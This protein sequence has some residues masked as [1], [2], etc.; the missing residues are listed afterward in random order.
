[1]IDPKSEEPPKRRALIVTRP[2]FEKTDHRQVRAQLAEADRQEMLATGERVLNRSSR[3]SSQNLPKP[4][5][6]LLPSVGSNSKQTGGQA[7]PASNSPSTA[8]AQTSPPTSPSASTTTAA[9]ETPSLTTTQHGERGALIPN[10]G[11]GQLAPELLVKHRT[12]TAAFVADTAMREIALAKPLIECLPPPLVSLLNGTSETELGPM[13]LDQ[14][15][16]PS[17]TSPHG[18]AANH[19]VKSPRRHV[20][21]VRLRRAGYVRLKQYIE[22]QGALAR[23]A[24]GK[25]RLGA[26]G[27]G[28]QIWKSRLDAAFADDAS[29]TVTLKTWADALDGWPLWVIRSAFRAHN[30]TAVHPPYPAEI[31]A[32]CEDL[33]G[34]GRR[35]HSRARNA[36]ADCERM[37]WH[38]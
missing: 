10:N 22:A 35:L 15:Q 16:C 1:M 32:I 11:A 4:I 25:Q 17:L 30:V 12:P 20:S 33:W 36:V 21:H 37:G 14:M 23:I 24:D 19:A 7:Q 2:V 31:L 28:L 5:S 18:A 27:E 3:Y 38:I 9:R 6:D 13:S 8:N 29:A 26:V 34:A